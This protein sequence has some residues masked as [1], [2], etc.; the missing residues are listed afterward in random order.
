M[1]KNLMG[2]EG[3]GGCLSGDRI[4]YWGSVAP[5]DQL[6]L[7]SQRGGGRGDSPP[8][9]ESTKPIASRKFSEH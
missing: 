8:T 1:F 5:L 6:K 7:L 3:P 9:P 2:R 4:S